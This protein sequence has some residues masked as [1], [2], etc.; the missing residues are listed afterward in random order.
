[1]SPLATMFSTAIP[2]CHPWKN[3]C[4][5][6]LGRIKGVTLGC[7][8]WV[9][10]GAE[11]GLGREVLMMETCSGAQLQLFKTLALNMNI[12]TDWCTHL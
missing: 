5:W 4:K 2:F 7:P 10:S 8:V 11:Q 12:S 3:V 6:P 9:K 1:M